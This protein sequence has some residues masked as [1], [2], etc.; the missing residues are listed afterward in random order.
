M[1]DEIMNDSG[2]VNEE[3]L[4]N[5]ENSVVRGDIDGYFGEMLGRVPG[6]IRAD[7]AQTINDDAELFYRREVEDIKTDMV[8]KMRLRENYL[9]MSPD[10]VLSLKLATEFNGKE[11]ATNDIK[12]SVDIRNLN[13]AFEVAKKR[14]ERLFGK[15]FE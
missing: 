13:I 15:V 2:E 1:S 8:K 4:S 6:K 9:D 12:L 11:F 14:Y 10:N 7:R 3:A 5:L